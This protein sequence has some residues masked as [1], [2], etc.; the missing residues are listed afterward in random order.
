LSWRPFVILGEI[1]FST[2]MLHLIILRFLQHHGAFLSDVF[3]SSA[4]A[5]TAIYGGSYLL[6]RY[7]EVPARRAILNLH[8]WRSK[9]RLQRELSAATRA[10]G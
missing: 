10:A 2:Y 3:T 7:W 1:S 4:V 8:G 5:L 9:S 6:W